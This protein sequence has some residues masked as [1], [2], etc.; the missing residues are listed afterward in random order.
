MKKEEDSRELPNTAAFQDEFTRSLLDSPEQ[1]EDGHYLFE[2]K[3]GG[4]S[5]LWPKNA[6]TDGPPF[7]QRTKDSFEKIIFNDINEKENYNY[8]FSTTYSTYGESA[9]ESS[10]GILSDSVSYNGEYEKIETDKTHI[11]FAKSED[12]Y[13]GITTYFFFGYIT[14]KES[15]KGLEYIFSTECIDESKLTCNIDI[16][17]GE[18]KALHYLKSVKFNKE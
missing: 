3:T 16:K 8:S 18:E 10:L 4:Y 17:K 14:S 6:V 7:Y 11:Y 5:M 13:A 2:S 15:Q 9:V 12:T 1:V